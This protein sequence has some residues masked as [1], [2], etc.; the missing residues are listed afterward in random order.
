MKT[1]AAMAYALLLFALSPAGVRAQAGA[2]S[3]S[4]R[5]QGT[6]I[7]VTG[8]ADGVTIPSQYLDVMRRTLSGS[9]LSVTQAGQTFFQ[10]TIR[11]DPSQSPR[12]IDYQMTAGPTAGGLQRGIYRFSGDTVTFCMAGAGGARPTDFTTTPGDGRTLSSWIPARP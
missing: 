7:M 4:A 2:V 12:T 5:L 6:W 8:S 9:T 10:A 3:D 11:L 1:N